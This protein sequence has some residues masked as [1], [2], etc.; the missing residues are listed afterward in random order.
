MGY[1]IK[2]HYGV[3]LLRPNTFFNATLV[4]AIFASALLSFAPI[5][6]AQEQAQPT[7]Q[8]IRDS[9]SGVV[10]IRNL[11]G[12]DIINPSNRRKDKTDN[13]HK[14]K[15]DALLIDL[16]EEM[17]KFVQSISEFARGHNCLLY[18][19]PSPRDRG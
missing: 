10:R 16:R 6:F 7:D 2:V 5:V 9:S 18:T 8:K 15:G 11:F 14:K 17:R 12:T 1:N 3:K 4:L 19:S 13:S